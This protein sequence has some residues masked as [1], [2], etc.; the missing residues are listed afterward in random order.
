MRHSAFILKLNIPLYMKVQVI[1]EKSPDGD[2]S[3]FVDHD[4]EHFGLAGYGDSVEDAKADLLVCYEEMR[5]LEAEEGREVPELEFIYKYDM[6]SFF[7]YFS[8][9]N[10]TKI[11]EV[12]GINPG[13]MRRYTCGN[14]KAGEKQY[15]RLRD[16]IH[17]IT[18]ELS[19]ATF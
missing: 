16:A 12:A 2:Y 19:A 4:F 18:T 15:A 14:I 9:L 3:C 7:N 1:V 6:Q 13:L 5:T 11:A 17:M 10:V 8:Y